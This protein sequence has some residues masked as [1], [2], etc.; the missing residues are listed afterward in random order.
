MLVL[1]LQLVSM[2][3]ASRIVLATR[4]QHPQL[5]RLHLELRAHETAEV[6][7]SLKL[8]TRHDQLRY[9]A[10]V[11]TAVRAVIASVR[12][13]D[14]WTYAFDE[15]RRDDASWFRF[16]IQTPDA[17][18]E[19]LVADVAAHGARCFWLARRG[20]L[21]WTR[22]TDEALLVLVTQWRDTGSANDD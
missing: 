9:I 7:A 10:E 12:P 13:Q 21:V 20:A 15:M 22:T 16:A 1:P 2:P 17:S 4:L 18:L 6:P 3:A 5:E 11:E 14:V 19:G 8:V